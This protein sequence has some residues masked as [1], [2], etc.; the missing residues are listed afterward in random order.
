MGTQWKRWFA[1]T[2]ALAMCSACSDTTGPLLC[3]PTGP[4]PSIEGARR[5]SLPPEPTQFRDVNDEWASIARQVPGGWGGFFLVD[6]QPT[7][8]LV[9]PGRRDEALAALHLLWD[10]TPYDIRQSDVWQGRWDFA[11]L[12]DWRRYIDVAVGWPEGLTSSDLDEFRNRIAYGVRDE[13]IAASFGALLDSANL[14][15][16]LVLIEVGGPIQPN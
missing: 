7:V 10:W 3:D 6:G 16:E 11:Q 9:E 13:G 15:C 12:Y 14:P 4:G 2:G 1:V 5:D 8:Y